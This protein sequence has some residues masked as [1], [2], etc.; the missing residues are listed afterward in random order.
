M[1]LKKKLQ[2]LCKIAKGGSKH[3]KFTQDGKVHATDGRLMV[4]AL[5]GFPSNARVCIADPDTLA[6]QVKS[7]TKDS[8]L[9]DLSL[10]QYPDTND[11]DFDVSAGDRPTDAAVFV[12]VD[13]FALKALA[14]AITQCWEGPKADAS[15]RLTY[16]PD[17][18]VIEMVGPD[19]L[20]AILKP[21]VNV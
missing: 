5:A 21:V 20:R 3:V 1:S 9:F 19:H 13:P 10:G 4:T 8:H 16:F 6:I 18:Q 2:A 15:V 12:D 14:D 17:K 7:M 11:A